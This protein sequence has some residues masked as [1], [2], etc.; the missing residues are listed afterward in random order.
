MKVIKMS[1]DREVRT[2]WLNVLEAACYCGLSVNAFRMHAT[3]D[4][5][6]GG[7]GRTRR[8][9]IDILSSWINNELDVPF[10]RPVNPSKKR[11][12][13]PRRRTATGKT[14]SAGQ[15]LVHPKNGTTLVIE[16]GGTP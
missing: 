13:K 7:Q 5:P 3:D 15:V 14:G 11:K 9:H 10:P 1:E 6:H 8:Y 12:V 2:P 4:V 16:G